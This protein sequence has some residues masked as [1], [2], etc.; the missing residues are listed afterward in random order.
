MLSGG[1]VRGSQNFFPGYSDQIMDLLTK[2]KKV[3]REKL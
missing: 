1:E 3:W 2:L